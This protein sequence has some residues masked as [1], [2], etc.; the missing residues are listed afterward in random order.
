MKKRFVL[1]L[2][3]L[4]SSASF[5]WGGTTYNTWCPPEVGAEIS[6]HRTFESG[7]VQNLGKGTIWICTGACTALAGAGT[8]VTPREILYLSGV[9]MSE[10][11]SCASDSGHAEP[12]GVSVVEWGDGS[13]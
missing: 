4:L 13:F 2:A 12:V 7:R 6:V 8:M 3:V 11:V 9:E 1:S 5:V 10:G